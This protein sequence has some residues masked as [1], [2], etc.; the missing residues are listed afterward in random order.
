MVVA[1][2]GI[3]ILQ[4][5]TKKSGASTSRVSTA[6][7][8]RGRSLD[9]LIT[10]STGLRMMERTSKRGKGKRWDRSKDVEKVEE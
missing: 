9:R 8:G 7:S 4:A 3:V 10:T 5:T 2:D 6:V 1:V